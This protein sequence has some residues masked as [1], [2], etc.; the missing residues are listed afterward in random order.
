MLNA[1]PICN[2]PVYM[3]ITCELL[4]QELK[5]RLLENGV[6]VMGGDKLNNNNDNIY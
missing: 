2:F 4:H 1:L 3:V 6:G 5:A